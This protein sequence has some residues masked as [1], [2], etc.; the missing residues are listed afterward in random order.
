MEAYD[1]A[2][3]NTTR[4]PAEM[5]LL[6]WSHDEDLGQFLQKLIFRVCALAHTSHAHASH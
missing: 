1:D 3:D 2:A 4:N 6:N 5:F